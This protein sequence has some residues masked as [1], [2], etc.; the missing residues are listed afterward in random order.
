MLSITAEQKRRRRV[1]QLMKFAANLVTRAERRAAFYS[2]VKL[3]ALKEI[4][5]LLQKYL[6][7]SR[8]R[9][10]AHIVHFMRNFRH[11]FP[12]IKIPQASIIGAYFTHPVSCL[13][14]IRIQSHAN[15][16]AWILRTLIVGGSSSY[17]FTVC[18]WHLC[19]TCQPIPKLKLEK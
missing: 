12:P 3:E 2:A 13:A 7:S 16:P 6:T 18:T 15:D 10:S 19:V 14:E 9:Q 8:Y 17:H 1:V 5:L 11:F 4:K